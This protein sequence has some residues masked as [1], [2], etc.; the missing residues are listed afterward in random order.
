MAAAMRRATTH[1]LAE[2]KRVLEA[3]AAGQPDQ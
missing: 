3:G 1:D 2:L